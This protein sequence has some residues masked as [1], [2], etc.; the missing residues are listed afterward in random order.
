MRKT[1]LTLLVML[2]AISGLVGCGSHTDLSSAKLSVS[3]DIPIQG[4]DAKAP[5]YRVLAELHDE[6]GKPIA[7]QAIKAEVT[8]ANGTIVESF[9]LK[10]VADVEGHYQSEPFSP[11][12][13]AVAGQ[14]KVKAVAA[15]GNN[16][17]TAESQHKVGDVPTGL[18]FYMNVPAIWGNAKQEDVS[19]GKGRII[20]Y[21]RI[22]QESHQEAM[23]EIGYEVGNIDN[24]AEA[25]EAKLR[26]YLPY[27]YKKSNEY[28]EQVAEV[29]IE[30]HKGWIARGGI[31]TALGPQVA[32]TSTATPRSFR[33]AQLR[34]TPTHTPEPTA[35]PDRNFTVQ[36]LRFYC[37]QSDRTFTI[38]AAATSDTLLT[39]MWG[40]VTTLDCHPD[41]D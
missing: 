31:V 24:T 6:F 10:P 7:N 35:R 23:I 4:A 5:K 38:I 2:F 26:S 16:G 25:V 20:R 18:G 9:N 15:N 41:A 27:G 29:V 33:A 36:V 34:G 39:Q 1:L 22:S 12:A 11:E 37:E 28:V 40:V 30:T 19:G 13:D 8:D 17:I 14:W 21:E 32:P 3:L